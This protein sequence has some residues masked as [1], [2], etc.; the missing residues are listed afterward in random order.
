[1]ESVSVTQMIGEQSLAN[2]V[3]VT[4]FHVFKDPMVKYVQIMEFVNVEPVNVPKDG[5]EM[6]AAVQL[7]L[8]NA[9]DPTA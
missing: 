3:N 4:T 2:I 9:M 8:I 5:L 7:Q 1:M 6:I